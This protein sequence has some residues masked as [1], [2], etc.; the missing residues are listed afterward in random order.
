MEGDLTRTKNKRQSE[1]KK[2]K[3]SYYSYDL[4]F[5]IKYRIASVNLHRLQ[6][7]T[8]STQL[9]HPVCYHFHLATVLIG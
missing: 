3:C 2:R 5:N 8:Y 7:D 1:T 9:S 6:L 4:C